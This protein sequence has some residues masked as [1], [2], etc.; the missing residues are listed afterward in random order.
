[1]VPA[2]LVPRMKGR[3][4]A[5]KRPR[6]PTVGIVGAQLVFVRKFL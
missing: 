3:R 1:M 5:K 4:S 2:M 6:V